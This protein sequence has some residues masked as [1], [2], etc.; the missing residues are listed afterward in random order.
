[1]A[2]VED[3]DLDEAQ[4][5]Q[6]ARALGQ[7]YELITRDDRLE[8]V[9]QGHR[10]PLPGPGIPRQGHGGVDRQGHRRPDL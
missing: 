6:L 9:A 2:I 10:R 5:R 7:Q 3:A 8:A 4:E 1:M